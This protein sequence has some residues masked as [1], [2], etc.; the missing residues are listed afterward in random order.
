MHKTR[1]LIFDFSKSIT[2]KS[3]FFS[4]HS[5]TNAARK[6]IRLRSPI[7][8][9]MSRREV[10]LCNWIVRLMFCFAIS[11]RRWWTMFDDSYFINIWNK[12]NP[13]RSVCLIHKPLVGSARQCHDCLRQSPTKCWYLI[14][15]W[16]W[17]TWRRWHFYEKPM[18]KLILSH[19]QTFQLR[20]AYKY[21]VIH[22]IVHF[23][24]KR[25]F[26]CMHMVHGVNLTLFNYSSRFMDSELIFLKT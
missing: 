12:L 21:N 22:D 19:L 1:L 25:Y 16:H 5:R 7:N 17:K 4:V 24:L 18:I 2:V 20:H 6:S 26:L 3:D 23:Y 13:T 15:R 14:K 10:L 11:T 8:Q 9:Q